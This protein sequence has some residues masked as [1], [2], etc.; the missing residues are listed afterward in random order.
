MFDDDFKILWFYLLSN[1]VVFGVNES[2][3]VDIIY[4]LGIYM[5]YV[6]IV[7]FMNII[8]IFFNFFLVV[9]ILIFFF[10]RQI[11]YVND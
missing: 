6:V 2:D 11:G 7:L 1:F 4:Q 8:V 9:V 5:Y 10:E 3:I